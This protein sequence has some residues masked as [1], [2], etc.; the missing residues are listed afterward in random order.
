MPSKQLTT[1]QGQMWDQIALSGV[2]QERA[3]GDVARANADLADYLEFS[4]EM[5]LTVPEAADVEPVRT[6]PPWERM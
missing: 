5:K 2:G 1:V 6:L 3:M 4:G